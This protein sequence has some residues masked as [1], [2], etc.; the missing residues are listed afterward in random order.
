M[1]ALL[2]A[3]EPLHQL[4]WSAADQATNKAFKIASL[5]APSNLHP[6]SMALTRSQGR[7]DYNMVSFSGC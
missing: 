5:P 1:M 2:K 7:E 6:D 4:E 3:N